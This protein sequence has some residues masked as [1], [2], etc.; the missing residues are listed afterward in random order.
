MVN[1]ILSNR[2]FKDLDKIYDYYEKIEI[3][4]GERF[5]IKFYKKY[6]QLSS[7]PKIGN[8]KKRTYRETYRRCF[9]IQ[10]FID[11]I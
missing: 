7:H 8:I 2:A 11:S 3:G 1:I 4:L 9:L 6:A 10:S 5:L